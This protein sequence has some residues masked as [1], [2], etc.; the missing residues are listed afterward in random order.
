MSE[1]LRNVVTDLEEPG[2]RGIE[3]KTG[4]IAEKAPRLHLRLEVATADQREGDRTVV[5][6]RVD[7]RGDQSDGKC[8]SG[9]SDAPE[10]S[11]CPAGE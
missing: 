10:A 2:L 7:Q 6:R 9:P 5:P 1:P 11:W 4:E 8:S 3:H